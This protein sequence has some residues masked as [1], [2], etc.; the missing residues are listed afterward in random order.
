MLILSQDNIIINHLIDNY[1]NSQLF[2]LRFLAFIIILYLIVIV[3]IIYF[4]FF[5]RVIKNYKSGYLN[6][7]TKNV[8]KRGDLDVRTNTKLVMLSR[9]VAPRMPVT[10]PV[11]IENFTRTTE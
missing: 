10:V 11:R 7:S 3:I 8:A 9:K 4:E 1:G 5:L 6:V 2:P